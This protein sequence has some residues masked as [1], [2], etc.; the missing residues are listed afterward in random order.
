MLIVCLALVSNTILYPFKRKKKKEEILEVKTIAVIP[1][2]T[3]AFCIYI[4]TVKK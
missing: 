4:G 1:D 3:L 2:A